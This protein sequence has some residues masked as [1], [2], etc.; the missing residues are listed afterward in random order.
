MIVNNLLLRLK[1][2]DGESI[3]RVKNTLLSMKGKIDVLIELQ[4]E[5]NIRHGE[6][7]YDI[8]LITKFASIADL[9]T[10]LAH[11]AHVEVAKYIGSAVD[12]QAA[13]CYEV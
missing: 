4:A 8:I 1:E 11:P 9:D 2:R 5:K 3:L 6:S 7:S 13:V 12:V 10:Y